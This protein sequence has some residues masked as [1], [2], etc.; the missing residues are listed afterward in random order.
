MHQNLH[1]N[2]DRPIVAEMIPVIVPSCVARWKQIV[3]VVVVQLGATPMVAKK[4]PQQSGSIWHL[5]VYD[6][7]VWQA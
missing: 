2:G 7:D 6:V 5:P 1:N 3:A 4:M